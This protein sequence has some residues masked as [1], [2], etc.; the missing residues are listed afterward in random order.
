MTMQA[1]SM[2]TRPTSLADYCG[3]GHLKGLLNISIK[4]AIARGEALGHCLFYG[5]PGTGK[6]AISRVLAFEMGSKLHMTSAP[7]LESPRD[8]VGLLNGLEDNDVL[9]IDEIHRLK[10][11]TEELLYSALEDY[12]LD[13]TT[14][15][16]TSARVISLPLPQFT[17]IGATTKLGNI[18]KP[19]RDRFTHVCKLEDYTVG[20]LS[21][22]VARAAKL[23]ALE[24][25]ESGTKIIAERSRGTPRIALRFV[26]L[27]RDYSTV[28]GKAVDE[29]FAR[30]ALDTYQVDKD[31][32]D[33]T[34]RKYLQ[35]LC[36][37]FG[38]G[39]TGLETLAARLNED[40]DMLEDV[41][42][43]FLLQK[44]LLTRTSRG[45][46]ATPQA[47]I[48]IGNFAPTPTQER[49]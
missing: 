36:E 9:F 41:T 10:T 33:Q 21:Q 24:I 8:I 5:A 38:G 20:E 18:S 16:G 12:R 30:E 13:L 3:Q 32:L 34:D 45:R 35:V 17:L 42:E 11:V 4:A 28:E 31:G 15:K 49:S 22:I 25:D 1:N 27:I 19:L 6:T 44:G 46:V 48:H 2:D 7:A 47:F 39:P 23:C 37:D 29:T 40:P 26:R 14:G 43:P